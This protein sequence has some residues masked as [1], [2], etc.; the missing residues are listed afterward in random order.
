MIDLQQGEI[1]AVPVRD[2]PMRP[3]AG[4]RHPGGLVAGRQFMQNLAA[5]G[6]DEGDRTGGLVGDQQASAV[7]AKRQRDRRAMR[8]IL[9]GSRG[10]RGLR[11]VEPAPDRRQRRGRDKRAQ[12]TQCHGGSGVTPLHAHRANSL[13]LVADR[14]S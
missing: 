14:P 13:R 5:H 8:L 3:I 7:I 12:D 1:V 11:A 9:G 10:W 2:D 6:V 4:D